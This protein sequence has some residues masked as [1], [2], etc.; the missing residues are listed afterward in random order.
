MNAPNRNLYDGRRRSQ[1]GPVTTRTRLNRQPL[2]SQ[3][4]EALR[5]DILLGRIRGGSPV[6]QQQL[7]DEYGVSR[8][9]VRDALLKLTHEGLIVSGPG[10]QS[11][12]AQLTANDILDAFDIEAMV[13]GRAARR[14]TTHA[15][16]QDLDEL[17]RLHEEM[18]AAEEEGDL[19]LV[20]DL[21]RR[22]HRQI[23]LLA[24]SPK[25][26]AFLRHASVGI[27]R[28]YIREMPEWA[29]RGNRA[30]VEILAAMRE[31]DADRVEDL[32]RGLVVASGAD[33]VAYLIEAG[34]LEAEPEHA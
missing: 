9:P 27:P 1:D 24:R 21:N 4:A 12:V 33:L 23:N 16:P 29:T 13:H 14:A 18:L 10:G 34:A 7:C 6:S 20:G 11:I 3:I 17:T 2:G 8:M 28:A 26:L 25:L 15:T 30:R 32:I 22:F 31:R 19:E 5:Q